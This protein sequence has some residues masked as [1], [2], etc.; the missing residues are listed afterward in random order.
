VNNHLNAAE[1]RLRVLEE[2][3]R[4]LAEQRQTRAANRL[5]V[6]FALSAG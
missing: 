5:Q 2:Y 3:S 1:R 6:L 4:D